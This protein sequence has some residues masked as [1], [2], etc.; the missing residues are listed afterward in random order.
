MDRRARLF[1]T[2]EGYAVEGGFD[3][4]GG[5]A[6]CY[7]PTIALGRHAGPGAADDLW[8]HY[9]SVL[10]FVPGLG[11]DG[12]RLSVEWARIEPRADEIDTAALARYLE[13][14]H[15]ARSLGLDVT[16]ALIDAVWPAWLG[17]EAWLL[18]WVAPYVLAQGRRVVEYFGDEIT[19]VLAFAQ[20][21][22]LV[23]NGYLRASAPPWRR[24]ALLDAGF[25]RAQIARITDDLREDEVVGP[26]LIT[27]STVVGLDVAPEDLIAARRSSSGS[28]IYV[29]SLVRGTGPTSASAGLLVHDGNDWRVSASEELLGALR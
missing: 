6:T 13:V 9:E 5:P 14:A 24:S 22:E 29:R 17:Q 8:R 19:G 23:A 3:Q 11:F 28:E 7:S 27:A 15:Y 2:L 10:D 18:P 4:V 21:N 16:V 20:P 12:I 1:V 25:A 26:K